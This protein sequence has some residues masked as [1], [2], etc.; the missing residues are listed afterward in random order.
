MEQPNI[1]GKRADSDSDRPM[2]RLRTANLPEQLDS[3]NSAASSADSVSSEREPPASSLSLNPNSYVSLGTSGLPKVP[4]SGPSM[5]GISNLGAPPLTE[6]QRGLFSTKPVTESSTRPGA[7]TVSNNLPAY[8]ALALGP[9]PGAKL[10]IFGLPPVG[11]RMEDLPLKRDEPTIKEE[12][13]DIV[14]QEPKKEP[15]L[16]NTA[17]TVRPTTKKGPI[18]PP[19]ESLDDHGD[20]T[21]V[22]GK[23]QT[24]FLVCS[25]SLRRV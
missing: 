6:P 22:V 23:K 4:T 19:V 2:K 3:A 24:R 8:N 14:K 1:F 18:I 21:L 17:E 5:F 9:F 11:L 20:L 16:E 13:K 15:G 25:H 10:S 7:S 12:Q